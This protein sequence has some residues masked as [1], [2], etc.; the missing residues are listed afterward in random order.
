MRELTF[1]DLGL[2]NFEE[3]WQLQKKIVAQKKH[4]ARQDVLIFCEHEPVITLG[5]KASKENIL[6]TETQLKKKNVALFEIDR[7]GDVTFHSPGQLVAYAL[8]SL[9][10]DRDIHLF[11]DKLE[12]VAIETLLSYNIQPNAKKETRGVWV[13]D[14]K[15]CS[16]G[17]GFSGWI[18]YHGIAV[19]INND[20]SLF[21]YIKPC[22]LS[23]EAMTSL[24]R[25]LEATQDVDK[26]KKILLEEFIK[27]FGYPVCNRNPIGITST[28]VNLFP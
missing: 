7:G 21:E 28:L 25:L 2:V 5:R 8:F 1:I 4:G 12:K 24:S 16:L 10:E 14:K 15:I 17:V 19:N 6:V 26:F 23:A 9:K 3:A 13:K 20:L 11:M 27:I 18:S 22:G